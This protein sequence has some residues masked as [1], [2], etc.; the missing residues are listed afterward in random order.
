VEEDDDRG[1]DEQRGDDLQNVLRHQRG[2]SPQRHRGR[3][4]LCALYASVVSYYEE[5][6]HLEELAMRKRTNVPWAKCEERK[7][8]FSQ[9]VDGVGR[10]GA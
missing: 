8:A 5:T 6:T 1:E 10:L 3:R 9:H 7:P 2:I 4:E